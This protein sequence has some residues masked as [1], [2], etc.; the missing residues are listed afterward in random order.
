[1]SA[2]YKPKSIANL[3]TW[4]AGLKTGITSDGPGMGRTPAQVTADT[5]FIDS[6]LTPVTAADTMQTQAMEAEGLARQ[7]VATNNS[8][9]RDLINNY[10]SSP[11]WNPGMAQAW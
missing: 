11:G 7:A 5:A 8:K 3:K 1:M 4:L 2:D 10:K 6:M 9:L